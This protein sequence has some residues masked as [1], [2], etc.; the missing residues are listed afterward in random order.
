MCGQWLSASCA[1]GAS[2]RRL[3]DS[4]AQREARQDQQFKC[5]SLCRRTR[6]VISELLFLVKKFCATCIRTATWMDRESE[7]LTTALWSFSHQMNQPTE[8][9][10]LYCLALSRVSATQCLHDARL[11]KVASVQGLS[12][13]RGCRSSR[14]KPV[15]G[16]AEVFDVRQWRLIDHHEAHARM[17][18]WDCVERCHCKLPP[19]SQQLSRVSQGFRQ[20]SSTHTACRCQVRSDS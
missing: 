9:S 8:Q 7:V 2:A 18:R 1:T 4:N 20:R 16:A 5:P 17:S 10:M 13:L 11:A 6:G 3:L 19:P 14:L 15:S 12:R